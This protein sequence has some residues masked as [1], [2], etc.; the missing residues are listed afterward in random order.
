VGASAPGWTPE[1]RAYYQ[2]NC[3][4]RDQQRRPMGR[5]WIRPVAV[6]V[7]AWLPPPRKR[8]RWNA[9][10]PRPS[11]WTSWKR[12]G[13]EK[14]SRERTAPAPAVAPEN[15]PPASPR[16][17]TGKTTGSSQTEPEARTGPG[18]TPR[19]PRVPQIRQVQAAGRTGETAAPGQ[20]QR[21]P[22]TPSRPAPPQTE[23]A[24][25]RPEGDRNGEPTP[26]R[27]RWC[28]RTGSGTPPPP[29]E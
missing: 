2:P 29:G 9:P 4:A 5:R 15:G 27:G 21:S 8:P 22:A 7:L 20:A 18:R 16:R 10:A 25:C 19:V 26:R 12:R 13:W 1:V 17:R 6:K 3:P 28:L 24:E 23:G 14:K 11:R